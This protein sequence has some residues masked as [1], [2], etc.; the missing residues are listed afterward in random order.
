MLSGNIL[1]NCKAKVTKDGL[2]SYL[3]NTILFRLKYEIKKYRIWPTWNK[4]KLYVEKKHTHTQ[5]TTKQ[6]NIIEC[7]ITVRLI[8]QEKCT[9][10]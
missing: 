6:L 9:L 2:R 5:K 8:M 4:K 10:Q 3:A 7:S 1:E